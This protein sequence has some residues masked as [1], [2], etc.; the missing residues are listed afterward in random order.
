[1]FVQDLYNIF[2]FNVASV[3]WSYGGSSSNP[4]IKITWYEGLSG[5]SCGASGNTHYMKDF[6]DV[7]VGPL[8][9]LEWRTR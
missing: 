6:Q 1:M 5:C 2:A 3:S 9:I 7:A 4:K 8:V